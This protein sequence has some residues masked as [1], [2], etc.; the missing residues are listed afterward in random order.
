MAER[1]T[2]VSRSIIAPS[3]TR[4]TVRWLT[5]FSCYCP[6]GTVSAQCERSLRYGINV[7]VRRFERRH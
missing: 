5:T 1:L 4:P 6:A 3:G 2:A 7:A